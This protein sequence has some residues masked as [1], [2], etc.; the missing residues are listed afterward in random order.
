[1]T[2]IITPSNRSRLVKQIII[3]STPSNRVSVSKNVQV[4]E[5]QP[6]QYQ[7]RA[8]REKTK[9]TNSQGR[10]WFF[11]LILILLIV[12]LSISITIYFVIPSFSMKNSLLN[13]QQFYPPQVDQQYFWTGVFIPKP[14]ESSL[15][16]EKKISQIITV[17]PSPTS[18]LAE[19]TPEPTQFVE[20]TVVALIDGTY[21]VQP[22]DTLFKIANSLGLSVDAIAQFNSINNQSVI[23]NGQRLQ[24][25]PPDYVPVVLE[26][27]KNEVS[28]SPVNNQYILVDISDQHLYAYESGELIYSFVASTGMNN[29]TR[30]GV[31]SVL[32]KIPNAY[33]ANWD[34]WMPDWLG[35]YW[36]GTLENGIHSLPILS[37]GVR[38]WSGYL[39]TPISYGCVVLG[40][41]ESQLLYDWVQVGTPVE[42]QW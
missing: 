37:N 29:S 8:V 23:Y 12:L 35:I 40:V 18:T 11:P 26:P 27:P 13:L 15:Q 38:L 32:D 7:Q 14:S 9:S 17:T 2:K 3:G 16:N 19:I 36:S 30:V 21:I 20:A 39:G 31:F 6:G 5:D 10:K 41:N 22:G 42:I 4:D 1:M 24:I 28:P 33:G 25:P 34:I